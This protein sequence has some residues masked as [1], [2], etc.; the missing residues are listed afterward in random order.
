MLITDDEAAQFYSMPGADKEKERLLHEMINGVTDVTDSTID[1][2]GVTIP[3]EE[4]TTENNILP[5][6]LTLMVDAE[7]KDEI[8]VVNSLRTL[9]S[10]M[11][12]VDYN[13]VMDIAKEF[14][15]KRV[16]KHCKNNLAG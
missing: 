13:Y 5:A 12:K 1:N 10:D 6:I 2:S 3:E 16:E 15:L 14:G 11:T 9:K 7:E 4:R 8:T